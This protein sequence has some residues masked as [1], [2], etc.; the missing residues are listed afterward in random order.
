MLPKQHAVSYQMQRPRVKIFSGWLRVIKVQKKKKKRGQRAVF[1][2]HQFTRNTLRTEKWRICIAGEQLSLV[3]SSSIA[4]VRENSLDGI[5]TTRATTSTSPTRQMFRVS[6]TLL[7]FCPTQYKQAR[8]TI[9]NPRIDFFLAVLR[10]VDRGSMLHF[11]K[12]AINFHSFTSSKIERKKFAK[13]YNR[14]IYFIEHVCQKCHLLI[15]IPG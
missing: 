8:V 3:V 15:L 4:G 13:K 6:A 1:L 2:G 10:F 12:F 9:A 11:E 14:L 7:Y 5:T